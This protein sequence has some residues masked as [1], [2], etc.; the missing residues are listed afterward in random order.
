MSG[1]AVRAELVL[2]RVPIP[3]HAHAANGPMNRSR[4]SRGSDR[5]GLLQGGRGGRSPATGQCP[6]AGCR[7]RDQWNEHADPRHGREALNR[8]HERHAQRRRRRSLEDRSQ[9]APPSQG[10]AIR[11]PARPSQDRGGTSVIKAPAPRRTSRRASAGV[12]QRPADRDVAGPADVHQLRLCRS[13]DTRGH[14]DTQ[15]DTEGGLSRHTQRH[16]RTVLTPGA[17]VTIFGWVTSDQGH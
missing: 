7:K 14:H 2:R 3:P 5:V 17:V 1:T 12:L 11:S 6:K 16:A 15:P 9:P 4:S 10:H 13:P 8:T